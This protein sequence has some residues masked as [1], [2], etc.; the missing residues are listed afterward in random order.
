VPDGEHE[1]DN[2]DE[3]AQARSAAGYIRLVVY[4][5]RVGTVKQ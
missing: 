4:C 1:K 5:L 2:K 3:S